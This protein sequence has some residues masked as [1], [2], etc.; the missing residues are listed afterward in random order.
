M[1][2]TLRLV[3]AIA[4]ATAIT[5]VTTLRANGPESWTPEFAF[6]VKRVTSV[7]PSPDGRHVAFVVGTAAMEGE[8]SEWV[9]QVWAADADGKNAVQLTRGDKSST[10]PTWS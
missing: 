3:V 2:M 4:I 9:S 5:P 8:K 1:R 6:K 7:R 10:S